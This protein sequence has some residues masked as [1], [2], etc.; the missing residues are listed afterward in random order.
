MSAALWENQAFFALF[1]KVDARS[2]ADVMFVRAEDDEGVHGV[3][4][5]GGA[6]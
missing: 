2:G 1:S 5:I 3:Q 6:A 4:S